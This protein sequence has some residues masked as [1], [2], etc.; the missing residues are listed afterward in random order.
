MPKW[1]QKNQGLGSASFFCG[2]GSDLLAQCGSGSGSR[3][4]KNADPMRIRIR[5]RILTHEFFLTKFF[6]HK[7]AVNSTVQ[8]DL[9]QPWTTKYL[10]IDAKYQYI[11][12]S[13]GL[14]WDFLKVFQR[15]DPDPD[16]HKNCGSGSGSERV[17][18]C[19][20]D[21]D[22]DPDPDPNPCYLL[23]ICNISASFQTIEWFSVF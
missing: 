5:I 2:S 11:M 9:M 15:S 23:L 12:Q 19:G 10:F 17:K 4:S 6:K 21:A 16:P 1:R 8:C 18:K 7:V 13:R 14:Y 22:P 20:S 3:G